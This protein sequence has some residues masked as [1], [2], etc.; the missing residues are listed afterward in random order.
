MTWRFTVRAV[1]VAGCVLIVLLGACRG[2]PAPASPDSPGP[3]R[4]AAQTL[5]PREVIAQVLADM[6]EA[7]RAGDPVRYLVHVAR[8]DACF[9]IE[10]QNWARDLERARP[11]RFRVAL[12]DDDADPHTEDDGSLVAPVVFEWQMPGA[13]PRR[14]R[15]DARFV[16][17]D[18]QWRYAGERWR[19]L[20]RG[21]VRVLY[22]DGLERTAQAVVQALAQVRGP[23][24]DFFGLREDAPLVKRTQEVKLYA[25]MMHLQQSIYLSYRDPLGGW[26]EPGES[27]K[28][29]AGAA[30]DAGMLRSVLAH[31]YAHVA[32]FEL[33]PHATR[34]PW[35]V[36][37]GVADLAAEPFLRDGRRTQRTVRRWARDGD[38]MPWD[39]L[40]D[41]HGDAPA[42]AAHVYI[43]GREWVRFI[44]QRH[45]EAAR[46]RWLSLLAQGH[47]LDEASRDALGIPFEMLDSQWRDSL[48]AE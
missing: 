33:G 9:T 27:I 28:M 18:G 26:T 3:H 39:A 6:T 5:T 25:F 35:W 45:G 11:E 36:L 4:G 42:H 14:V 34:M 24:H 47:T 23:V 22:P 43:Q 20:E 31:E 2:T 12:A 46:T 13:A 1:A 7:V 40:A 29:L 17:E 21:G 30:P 37:E 19:R 10:Q 44:T 16:E 15:F 48:L 38:L 32:T 8:T 41:F